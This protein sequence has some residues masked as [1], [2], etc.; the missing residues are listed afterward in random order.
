M[1]TVRIKL[2]SRLPF[3]LCRVHFLTPFRS[4]GRVGVPLSAALHGNTEILPTQTANFFQIFLRTAK[5]ARLQNANGRKGNINSIMM[6]CV[7]IYKAGISRGGGRAFFDEKI[8]SL[9]R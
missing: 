7:I 6:M 4:R 3:K 8:V 2:T 1:F 5:C 9:C